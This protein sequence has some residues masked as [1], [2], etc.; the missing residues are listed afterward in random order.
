MVQGSGFEFRVQGSGFR[1][2]GSGFRVQGSG[3]RV[4]P[5]RLDAAEVWLQGYLLKRAV[6]ENPD[7]APALA[8]YAGLLR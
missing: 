6:E 5:T 8:S 7:Y 3:F 2:Q 4:P 1:V